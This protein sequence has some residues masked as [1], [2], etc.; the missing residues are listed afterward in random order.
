[1]HCNKKYWLVL[2]PALGFLLL[3][4]GC[5]QNISKTIADGPVKDS[6]STFII[7]GSTERVSCSLENKGI[8]PVGFY[9]TP[10]SA[11]LFNWES[12]VH[13]VV[14]DSM[15]S[16]QKSI[17][18]WKFVCEWRYHDPDACSCDE[19]HEPGIMFN[20]MEAGL[21]DDA[22]AVL[23]HLGANAGLNARLYELGGHV[24]TEFNY[25]N[26]WHLFDADHEIYY[27]NTANEIAGVE[28]IQQHPEIFD[29]PQ[30]ESVHPQLA[31]KGVKS[32]NKREILSKDDNYPRWAVDSALPPY[33]SYLSLRQG[34]MISFNVEPETWFWKKWSADWRGGGGPYFKRN[35]YLERNVRSAPY[36]FAESPYSITSV[37]IKS[38]RDSAVPLL[39]VYY[40]TDLAHWYFKGIVSSA[41]S[42][43]FNPRFISGKELVFK[44]Y[45]KFVAD[46]EAPG[47]YP[48]KVRNGFTFSDKLFFN[49]PS[50]SFKIKTLTGDHRNLKLHLVSEGSR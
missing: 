45:L 47:S 50:H 7:D 31:N 21:C 6:V 15:T 11:D 8:E 39:K 12:I 34:D 40:S 22:A 25:N 10:A 36:I 42:V 9:I 14:N 23:A 27:R 30:V 37:T 2:L 20:A 41:S 19:L 13:S 32:A 49:N 35:G 4:I 5:R 16:E 46:D 3:V 18:L 26:H 44:Y 28:D 29:L 1:M 24:V 38:D 43:T 33:N 17:A 48:L